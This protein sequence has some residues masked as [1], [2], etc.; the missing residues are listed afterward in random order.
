MTIE[1][2]TS[3]LTGDHRSTSNVGGQ[4]N[5]KT[6]L[7]RSSVTAKYVSQRRVQIGANDTVEDELIDLLIKAGFD[8]EVTIPRPK[9]GPRGAKDQQGQAAF[10]GQMPNEQQEFAELLVKV[11]EEME[12][13]RDATFS[14]PADVSRAD[15]FLL[16]R[17]EALARHA[18]LLLDGRRLRGKFLP[19]EIFGEPAWDMLLDLFC[20]QAKGKRTS[21]TSLCL[22]SAAPGTTS[23]RYVGIL[24]SYGILERTPSEVD[25]RVTYLRLSAA[26]LLR[27][28]AIL[29]AS[30]GTTLA[31]TLFG[32]S[33]D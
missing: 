33:F 22:A 32:D 29:E 1:N 8:I 3:P 5:A 18:R 27:V 2:E 9:A 11:A 23:L 15:A 30:L 25:G 7:R 12:C 24:T 26:G 19:V 28:A 10:C 4:A 20:E 13:S 6:E 17:I 14:K 31:S 16:H 21:V